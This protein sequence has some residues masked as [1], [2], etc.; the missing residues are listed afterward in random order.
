MRFVHLMTQPDSLP[1]SI[2]VQAV[3]SPEFSPNEPI[4][5]KAHV[6]SLVAVAAMVAVRAVEPSAWL[7]QTV[8]ATQVSA[9]TRPLGLTS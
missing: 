1:F 7:P 9:V 4:V 3:Q 5:H 8:C 6:A 2:G